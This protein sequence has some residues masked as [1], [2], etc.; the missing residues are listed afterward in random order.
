MA[1][2]EFILQGLTPSSHIDAVRRL[3]DLSDIQ[4]VLLGVAFINESGVKYIEA[5]LMVNT[6]CVT[7]FAGI[8]NDITSYQGLARLHRVV[9]RLYTP[10]ILA[11]GHLSFIPSFSWCVERSVHAYLSEVQTSLLPG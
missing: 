9:N 1:K 3:F 2:T 8:R 5:Q 4:N 10:L 6:P 7:V 11:H